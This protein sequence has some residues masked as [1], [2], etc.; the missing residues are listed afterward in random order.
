MIPDSSG[1]L[2]CGPLDHAIAG[3][4]ISSFNRLVAWLFWTHSTNYGILLGSVLLGK[5]ILPK[6]VMKLNHFNELS[7]YFPA[8][9]FF[10]SGSSCH[11]AKGAVV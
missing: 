8:C 2:P 7:G 4:E 6:I 9:R 1:G 5:K 10:G 3:A 11:F